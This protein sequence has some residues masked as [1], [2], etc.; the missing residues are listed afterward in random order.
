MVYKGSSWAG[1][2]Q[3]LHLNQV[4]V[5][6]V[7]SLQEFARWL[8]VCGCNMTYSPKQGQ[9]YEYRSRPRDSTSRI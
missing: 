1:R 3:S 2:E 8:C 7:F 4:A 9:L 5:T 6:R